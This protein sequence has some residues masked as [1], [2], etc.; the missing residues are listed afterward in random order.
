MVFLDQGPKSWS[1]MSFISWTGTRCLFLGDVLHRVHNDIGLAVSSSRLT[2]VKSQFR[3]VLKLRSGPY[4]SGAHHQL[5]VQSARLMRAT[6]SWRQSL[7]QFMY[8]DVAEEHN[9]HMEPDFG[10]PLHEKRVWDEV[11]HRFEH[12]AQL[13][14]VAPCRWFSWE[15]AGKRLVEEVGLA[16]CLYLFLWTGMFRGLWRTF[17]DSPLSGRSMSDEEHQLREHLS[18][19]NKQLEEEVEHVEVAP[20]ASVAAA[21]S[22]TS[23]G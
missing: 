22:A 20:D 12:A 3:V 19:Q 17:N 10:T 1:A 18:D 21:S 7:W 4:R 16:S 9:L 13:R 2:A 23:S 15:A 11:V 8:A 6:Q 14:D 5:L